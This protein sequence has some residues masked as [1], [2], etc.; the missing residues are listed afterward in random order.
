M[1]DGTI[2]VGWD[3]PALQCAATLLADRYSAAGELRL[4]DCVLVV[5]GARAGRRLKEL[6][7]DVATERRLRLI[8]PRV[9]TIGHLP[10]L[11]YVPPAPLADGALARRAW[12]RSLQQLRRSRL[13]LVFADPP[14]P[15]D[16]HGWLALGRR[17]EQL[18]IAVAAG[19]LTFGDVAKSFGGGGPLYDDAQRWDVLAEAQTVYAGLLAA[20]GR[21]DRELA[22]IDAANAG[23]VAAAVEIWLL[24]VP[25][26]P[27]VVRRMLAALPAGVVRAMVHAPAVMHAGFDDLGCVE[28]GFWEAQYVPIPDNGFTVADRPADQAAAVMGVLA[29]LRGEFAADEVAVAVPDEEVAPFIEERLTAAGAPSRR[30]SGTPL[31]LSPPFRL[32][33]G[34]ADVLDGDDAEAWAALV[35]HPDLGRW[36]Q[37]EAGR[38][39]HRGAGA[40]R[41]TDGWLPGLDEYQST[42]LQAR[43][44]QRLPGDGATG[45]DAVEALMAAV[46]GPRLLGPLRGKRRLADWMPALMELLLQVYGGDRLN[47]AV[48]RDWRLLKACEQIRDAAAGIHRLPAELDDA[49]C[50]AAAALRI[51]LDE[52][53][54]GSVPAEPDRAAV[55]LLGWLELHLDDAPVAIITGVNEASL[56]ASVNADPF[57]PDALRTALG[58]E[59]NARRYARDAYQLTAVLHSRARTHVIAG[60]RSATGDP[61]RASRLLLAVP[62]D[63]LAR[64]VLAFHAGAQDAAET[65]AERRRQGGDPDGGRTQFRLPPDPVIRAPAPIDAVRVTQFGGLLEN[66]YLFAFERVLRLRAA[67]DSAREIDPMGFGSLAHEI[68]ERFGRTPDVRS[69][70]RS[71]IEKRLHAILDD[72]AAQRFGSDPYHAVP[73]QLM[74]L[75]ERLSAFARWQA[76][77]IA[78]G[79]H[80]VGV[81]CCTV[82]GGVNF[83]VDGDPIRLSGRIDR[84]D[85]NEQTRRW[86]VFDYKT[87]ERADSPR[88]AHCRGRGK[89]ADIGWKNLQL[90]LYRHILPYVVDT[91]GQVV[92]TGSLDDVDLGFILLCSDTDAV[93]AQLADW[94]AEELAVADEAARACVRLLRDNEFAYDPDL[95]IRYIDEDTAALLGVGRRLLDSLDGDAEGEEGGAAVDG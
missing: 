67:D 37:T 18:H 78:D 77:W 46:R 64:R 65:Q 32:L 26:M 45:R 88:A 58:L 13:Q 11:L 48:P 21:S 71:R 51:L 52:A 53:R 54:G 90:P 89:G 80:V 61:L 34:M 35:R 82:D 40:L 50:D 56:P 92:F 47:R 36:L 15:A 25:E 8:P 14:A 74:Q 43:L 79:W 57:L 9:T 20:A 27:A 95:S 12:A 76:G 60:R 75:R 68:L 22:R 66:P 28:P 63:D 93:G 24:A 33:A 29:S 94:T 31:D 49:A 83:D 6:L 73:F 70:D 19:G 41:L 69:T 81:E 72:C 23:S 30:G 87:G 16:L 17:V 86:A 85:Y 4:R 1:S 42:H 62:G 44:R 39:N 59:D 2:H 5:P 84:I 7:L 10:E 3:R 91:D 38:L 55:E